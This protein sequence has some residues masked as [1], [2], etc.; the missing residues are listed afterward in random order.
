MKQKGM[1]IV[2]YLLCAVMLASAFVIGA[3]A[4]MTSTGDPGEI[5]QTFRVEKWENFP[6]VFEAK[7][8]DEKNKTSLI[9]DN[10]KVYLAGTTTAINLTGKN[11]T[12]GR[13]LAT[14]LAPDVAY[15]IEVDYRYSGSPGGTLKVTNLTPAKPVDRAALK[16]L[17]DAAGGKVS[18]R[19]TETYW[20]ALIAAKNAA[21]TVYD[22][23]EQG[24][25]YDD[26]FEDLKY[27]LD[28]PEK[29]TTGIMDMLYGIVEMIMGMISS[30]F[31]GA[32][33]F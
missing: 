19:Y 23:Y 10:W 2:S 21:K 26:A 32:F 7:L 3:S 15:D 17:L 30:L 28:H 16:G 33:S 1:K 13:Y 31:G 12:E 24:S 4:A 22:N 11:Q 29:I 6:I 25:A 14:S 18:A 9:F 20:N 8:T 27:L 5:S